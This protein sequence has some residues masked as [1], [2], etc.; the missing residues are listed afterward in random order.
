MRLS[1][2]Q[3]G[4]SRRW[5]NAA[6]TG[7]SAPGPDGKV[8]LSSRPASLIPHTTLSIHHLQGGEDVKSPDLRSARSELAGR[9]R[10]PT[11]KTA[12]SRTL[13]PRETLRRPAENDPADLDADGE[14]DE[15]GLSMGSSDTP[16]PHHYSYGDGAGMFNT[17][18]NNTSGFHYDF[19]HPHPNS[20]A[21]PSHTL[22]YLPRI[23]HSQD[24]VHT[25]SADI[26]HGIEDDIDLDTARRN[27]YPTHATPGH[28]T[29]INTQHHR[30]AAQGDDPHSA[31]FPSPAA[32]FVKQE[33]VSDHGR[34]VVDLISEPE[35]ESTTPR[36]IKREAQHLDPMIVANTHLSISVAINARSTT[37]YPTRLPLEDVYSI[38][39]TP[40]VS[41]F[42]RILTALIE[43]EDLTEEQARRVKSAGVTYGWNGKKMRLRKGNAADWNYFRRELEAGWTRRNELKMEQCEVA[44]EILVS[45]LGR[46]GMR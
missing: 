3:K 9:S 40:M 39:H 18:P 45:D 11:T 24:A 28:L 14:S 38:R 31:T 30:T 17:D 2:N 16:E 6:A 19:A 34:D 23:D 33:Q 5:G 27:S 37:P 10:L 1:A 4:M 41:L 20:I 22:A 8:K 29:P 25:S 42:P 35:H 7:Q 43:D 44:L 12:P 26:F 15:P 21:G 46:P 32:G 13:R 36:K